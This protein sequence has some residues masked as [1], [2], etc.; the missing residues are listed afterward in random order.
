MKNVYTAVIMNKSGAVVWTGPLKDYA[1]QSVMALQ[2]Q[3]V[4]DKQAAA[5]G[6][7]AVT[8]QVTLRHDTAPDKIVNVSH[9]RFDEHGRSQFVMPEEKPAPAKKLVM[10]LGGTGPMLKLVKTSPKA[11]RNSR[12]QKGTGLYECKCCGH[13]TRSTGQGDNEHVG[14]CTVCYDLAGEE[15]HLSDNGTFYGSK[16]DITGLLKVLDSRNPSNK[17]FPEVRA[18][19]ATLEAEPAPAPA[20]KAKAKNIVAAPVKK[21]VKPAPSG[22]ITVGDK[23]LGCTPSGTAFTGTIGG[24]PFTGPDR[25]GRFQVKGRYVPADVAE[26]IR[27]AFAAAPK[28]SR[29]AA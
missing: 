17:L 27:A 22:K 9:F 16:G 8:A 15:N 1:R 10:N 25:L 23:G 19:L 13:K 12:F 29:K 24:V 4:L 3:Q 20:K 18:H 11:A 14:L 2:H 21:A 28:R 7:E 6:A 26:A 5:F